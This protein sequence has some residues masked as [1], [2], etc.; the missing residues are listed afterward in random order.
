[1]TREFHLFRCNIC[2]QLIEVINQ[3]AG[4]LV[5][6]DEPME[7]LKEN[8]ANTENKHYAHIEELDEQRKLIKFNH[9][10]TEA[11]YIEF[12]EV[13]SL[14]GRYLKRKHYLPNDILELELKCNCTEGFYIRLYCNRDGVWVTK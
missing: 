3:N 5:C 7:L 6:C 11:H 2:T 13:I 1:M 8:L 9:E 4:Q 12:V 10:M 14:D